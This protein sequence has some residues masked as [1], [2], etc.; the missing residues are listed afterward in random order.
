MPIPDYQTL[1]LPLLR[2]AATTPNEEYSL[3]GAVEALAE[4]YHLTDEERQ[5]LLPSGRQQVFTN[6]VGWARTYLKKASLL[7]QS[8]RGFLKISERG[9]ERH[10]TEPAD[11]K[12][13]IFGAVP[14]VHRV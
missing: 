5:Q 13:Q 6:R 12:R 14:W 3:Q 8:R 9:F 7:E 4:Q 2:L 1:M 10:S 11:R